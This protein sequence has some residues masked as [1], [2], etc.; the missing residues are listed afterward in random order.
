[1]KNSLILIICILASIFLIYQGYSYIFKNRETMQSFSKSPLSNGLKQNMIKQNIWSSNCPVPLERLNLLK[2]SYIDFEGIEHHDGL[3]VVHDVVADYVIAIFRRLYENKFP[4]ANVN[5]INDYNGD[6][7]KSMKDNN[8]SAF[9]CRNILNS[10]DLSIHSYGLAID[11]NPVQNP[12][13]VGNYEY[14]KANLAVYPALG[15]E[16]INRRN[17]RAGM[18]ESIVTANG[19]NV[20]DIFSKYG[21]TVWGGDWNT[22]IDWHH[23]QV[24]REQAQIIAKL[25]YLEGVDFFNSLVKEKI[26]N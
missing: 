9:N 6:D 13:L 16:Y 19:E 14:G 17:I 12:Y 26:S 4:I 15:I 20:I 18:V 21:F 5:L 11:I 2:V 3:L 7:D 25:P 8:S 23:F 24:T 22:P 1:M 10:N